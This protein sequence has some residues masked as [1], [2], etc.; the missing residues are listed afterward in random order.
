VIGLIGSRFKYIIFFNGGLLRW[1]QN[2][3]RNN[4]IFI[5]Y[6]FLSRD[7]CEFGFRCCRAQMY[8][9]LNKH[10]ALLFFGGAKDLLTAARLADYWTCSA[11][12]PALQDIF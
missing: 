7:S 6:V 10:Y 4:F 9:T 5:L 12:Y 11:I 2:V 8:T 3:G 1:Y